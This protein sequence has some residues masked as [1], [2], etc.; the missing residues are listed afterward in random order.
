MDIF[1]FV[2]FCRI[3]SQSGEIV[4]D[5]SWWKPCLHLLGRCHNFDNYIMNLHFVQKPQ[6]S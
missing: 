4:T 1:H 3:V 5:M 6:M 2:V